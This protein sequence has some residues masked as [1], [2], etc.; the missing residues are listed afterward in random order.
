[1][2]L[3]SADDLWGMRFMTEAG[4]ETRLRLRPAQPA[5]D[6]FLRSVYASTRAPELEQV[7]WSA[8]QKAAFC[9]MQFTAQDAH[10]RTH[11]PDARFDIVE[12]DGV[13]VGRQ[14][15][16]RLPTEVHL[17]DIAFLPG[18][19]NLGMGTFLL[20]QLMAEAAAAGQ[21]IIIYVE[22]FNPALQLYQRLGF[23]HETEE[24]V[25]FKMRWTSPA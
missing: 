21:S 25:Y 19:R 23:Q 22:R 18:H 16:H 1:M 13:P 4:Y 20:R 9:D 3:G 2:V 5:D 12:H 6:S 14:Y 24:G 15:V 7:P 11:F 10:Y 8:G 17:L